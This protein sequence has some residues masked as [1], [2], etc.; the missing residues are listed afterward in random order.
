V[1]GVAKDGATTFQK[2]QDGWYVLAGGTRKFDFEIPSE[3]CQK[4]DRI[5]IEIASSLVDEKGSPNI[6]TREMNV[7]GNA[8][9]VT[10]ASR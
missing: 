2:K 10:T 7:E 5:R 8:C 6:L 4:T 3:A 9:D 1:T